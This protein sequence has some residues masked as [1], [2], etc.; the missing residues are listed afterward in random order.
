MIVGADVTH[1]PPGQNRPSVAAVCA[2]NDPLAFKYNIQIRLQPPRVEIIQDMEAIMKEHLLYFYKS[3]PRLKPERIIFYRD[4]VSEG[5]F[6]E[7]LRS[8]VSAIRRA[9][10]SLQQGY[11]P[12]VTFIVVQKR[13]HTR[14]FPLLKEDEDG[15]NRNVPAGTIVD[16][17]ITHPVE[18]DFF[19][20][21]HASIQGV[22]RPTK[23]HLLWNDDDNMTT[24]E[25]E[26]LTYYLCHLFSRCTR[27]VSYPAPT[28]NAHLAAYRAGVYLDGPTISLK[29]LEKEQKKYFESEVLKR[30]IAD[31]PMYFV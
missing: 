21:S 12:S 15:K 7:V 17:K 24:D 8:E 6:L 1:P 16:S 4:G 27:S 31:S 9:C 18:L 30:I 5:Q 2:S 3:T 13:H 10:A 20:A 25:I 29:N 26:R 23:Y 22:T 19:L 14:F 11:E 28:Y